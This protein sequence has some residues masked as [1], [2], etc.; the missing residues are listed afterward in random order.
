MGSGSMMRP[1]H[2]G[3]RG[4]ETISIERGAAPRRRRPRC[5][6][7]CGVMEAGPTGPY[8]APET[9]KNHRVA[10]KTA[11]RQYLISLLVPSLSL[12]LFSSFIGPYISSSTRYHL[13][14][15]AAT[16]SRTLHILPLPYQ[17]LLDSPVL[18]ALSLS[19]Y[20]LSLF[21][22]LLNIPTLR[23]LR[24]RKSTHVWSSR[25]SNR[26]CGVAALYNC[27]RSSSI[28]YTRLSIELL[29]ANLTRTRIF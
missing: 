6:C 5:V 11:A 2:E 3:K 27:L 24:T 20:S 12:L 18:A 8:R 9:A 16:L 4:E 1:R 23:G 29:I 25:G 28:S 21:G 19:L 15:L 10:R 14:T 26:S 22:P 13:R 7:S 17:V